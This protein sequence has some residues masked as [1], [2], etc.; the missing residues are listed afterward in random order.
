MP[1]LLLYDAFKEVYLYVGCLSAGLRPIVVNLLLLLS[2]HFVLM[3]IGDS[4][5][6]GASGHIINATIII[7]MI[8]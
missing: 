1:I 7:I 6:C 8:Y 3:M 4:Q 5:R 2:Q